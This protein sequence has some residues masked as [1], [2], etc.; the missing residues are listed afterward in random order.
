MK[1]Y[2]QTKKPADGVIQR[3][4]L[5]TFSRVSPDVVSESSPNTDLEKSALHPDGYNLANIP[6][7]AKPLEK[8]QQNITYGLTSKLPIQA[9]LTIGEPNDKYEQE[10][11]RVAEQVIQQINIPKRVQ[12]NQKKTIQREVMLDKNEENKLQMKPLIQGKADEGGIAA[13]P[14]LES[15]IQKL[16]GGGQPLPSSVRKPMEQVFGADLSR[17]KIHTDTQADQLSQAIQAKAFT[18]RQDIFFQ[19]HNYNPVSESGQR[20]IAH[21]LTHVLQQNRINT[22]SKTGFQIGKTSVEPISNNTVQRDTEWEAK[23]SKNLREKT[24]KALN[25][26]IKVLEGV[27]GFDAS[28]YRRRYNRFETQH[29]EATR[30]TM[31]V[32]YEDMGYFIMDIYTE[33]YTFNQVKAKSFKV[34]LPAKLRD[35]AELKE[36]PRHG[37]AERTI[38]NSNNGQHSGR[39]YHAGT[40]H[41]PIPI[42][43]YKQPEHYVDIPHKHEIKKNIKKNHK[44]PYQVLNLAGSTKVNFPKKNWKLEDMGRSMPRRRNAEVR[45]KLVSEDYR[46]GDTEVDHI[47][48]MGFGG[49]DTLDNLWPLQKD[50]NQRPNSGAWRSRYR[51]FYWNTKNKEIREASINSYGMERKNYKIKNFDGMENNGRDDLPSESGKDYAGTWDES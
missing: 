23:K 19:K 7:S 32:W 10:A 6:I 13:T 47:R 24:L 11:D 36:V 15:S 38:A 26:A 4:H 41:D 12:S 17:V 48:D 46:L 20:L 39:Q 3:S 34:G 45:K 18:T 42:T 14:E 16:R 35:Y 25:N 40:A 43:F 5:P 22:D 49:T 8:N 21:E 31:K 44:T 33:V 1:G 29:E 27:P 28:N 2:T 51:F 37:Q 50:V 9:K 30:A